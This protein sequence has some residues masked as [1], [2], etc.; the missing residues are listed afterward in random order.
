MRLD[1]A[2]Q[3]DLFVKEVIARAEAFRE[4][5]RAAEPPPPV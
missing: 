4:Q 1:L 3:P 2:T 5:G